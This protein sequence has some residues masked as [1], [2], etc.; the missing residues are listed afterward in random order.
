MPYAFISGQLE[1]V[2]MAFAAMEIANNKAY[3]FLLVKY[4]LLYFKSLFFMDVFTANPDHLD[5]VN[6][7]VLLSALAFSLRGY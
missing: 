1:F 4:Q 6:L 5:P 3:S 2:Q 7:P